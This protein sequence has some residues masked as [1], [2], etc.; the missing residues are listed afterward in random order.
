[1]GII[2]TRVTKVRQI[3][4]SEFFVVSSAFYFYSYLVEYGK[5]EK[6]DWEKI[7]RT[8]YEDWISTTPLMLM[9]LCF[10]LS[11]ST[12]INISYI[13]LSGIWFADVAMLYSGY[14]GETGIIERWIACLFG[15]IFYCIIF[16]YIYK[17]FLQSRY[18][19]SNYAI[20]GLYCVIWALYGIVYL[21][22]QIEKN[23]IM[24]ILDFIAKPVVSI[25]LF[26]LY[27]NEIFTSH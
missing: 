17:T 6:I 15:F 1:M 2:F 19:F 14:L 12:G 9:S 26:G 5:E 22:D 27:Y 21:L 3:M 23:I 7:I 16:F 8:R 18:I 25:I 13:F 24:N 20:Y 11:K 10:V 4:I